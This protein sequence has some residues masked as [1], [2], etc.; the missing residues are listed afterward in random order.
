MSTHLLIQNSG[1]LLMALVGALG[2][3][4]LYSTYREEDIL[5]VKYLGVFFGFFAVFQF[6]LGLRSFLPVSEAMQTNIQIGA[7]IF[8]YAGMAYFARIPFNIY[9]PEWEK[10]VF[11]AVLALGA[12]AMAV[13]FNAGQTITPLIAIPAVV[14]WLGLGTGFFAY[15]AYK[16]EGVQRIKMAL[17]SAG[18]FLLALAGPMHNLPIAEE[19]LVALGLIESFTIIGT[20]VAIAGVYYDHLI[21]E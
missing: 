16:R 14:I 15:L 13:M 19:S 9:R 7:H 5:T 21:E 1:S 4:K 3:L 17:I 8:M 6:F 18:I 20:L 12:V 2:F 11:G 10:Y